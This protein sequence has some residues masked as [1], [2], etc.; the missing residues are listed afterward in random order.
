M[1]AVHSNSAAHSETWPNEAELGSAAQQKVVEL[2]EKVQ[3][4]NSNFEL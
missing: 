1:H 2:W 4:G 3:D